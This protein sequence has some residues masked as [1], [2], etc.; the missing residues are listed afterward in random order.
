MPERQLP[1]I[2]RLFELSEQLLESELSAQQRNLTTSIRETITSLW[3]LLS[4]QQRAAESYAPGAP[5]KFNFQ[6]LL[7]TICQQIGGRIHCKVEP[8]LQMGRLGDP[9]TLRVALRLLLSSTPGK[10]EQIVDLQVTSGASPQLVRF[11]VGGLGPT[12]DKLAGCLIE[13][14]GGSICSQSPLFVFELPLAAYELT[15]KEALLVGSL[16]GADIV[17]ISP[18]RDRMRKIL[19]DSL[20]C[21]LDEDEASHP[22]AI[23]L[24]EVETSSESAERVR[25]LQARWPGCP[26]VVVL[27]VATRGDAD[28]Y[29]Q[30]GCQA[31]LVRPFEREQLVETLGALL[32]TGASDFVTKHGL[33]ESGLRSARVL[34]VEDNPTAL[35]LTGKLVERAGHHPIAASS[36][37]E[38]LDLVVRERPDV[39]LLD[40]S[41]GDMEGPEVAR[42]LHALPQE[43]SSIPIIAATAHSGEKVR[44]AIL[45]AGIDDYL[46][47]PFRF[48]ELYKKLSQWAGRRVHKTPAPVSQ[49]LAPPPSA[50]GAVRLDRS[51]LRETAMNDP[52]FEAELVT[53]FLAETAGMLRKM[54][55]SPPDEIRKLAHSVNG[56]SSTLG[57]FAL[58]QLAARLEFVSVDGQPSLMKELEQE[59]LAVKSELGQDETS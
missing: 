25:R 8:G 36:G 24:D 48:E 37:Q 30:L 58:A 22:K 6:A 44:A 51:T 56:S 21:P 27:N 4:D 54:A 47:K 19:Q 26:L 52:E 53:S 3:L 7:D 5:I 41:L 2:T 55:G 42:R 45:E 29:Q 20:A 46:S 12:T 49:P 10:Q 35:M 32:G 28:F 31:L 23:L 14:L 43:V 9:E 40:F 34:I 59:F 57:V 11:E 18:Q 50:S 16:K 39:I 15:S 38:A 13:R 1:Q 33:R 17:V